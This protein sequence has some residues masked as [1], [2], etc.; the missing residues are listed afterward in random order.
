MASAWTRRPAHSGQIRTDQAGVRKWPVP[1]AGIALQV[2]P[3]T[4]FSAVVTT[5]IY[6]RPGCSARPDPANVSQFDLA[7]AAEVAGYRACMRCRPYR[8][9][10]PI[11]GVASEV[12]CRGIRLV[13][14]GDARGDRED[15][16]A[17]R[18]GL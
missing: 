3:M 17:R 6:C 11:G 18:L 7:A 13:V 10:G 4:G 5:G 16:V 1:G 2:T 14:A 15:A 8:V 12:V 9:S